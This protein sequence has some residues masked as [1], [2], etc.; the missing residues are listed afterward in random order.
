MWLPGHHGYIV[1]L[2]SNGAAFTKDE[3]VQSPSRRGDGLQRA[4]DTALWEITPLKR[5]RRQSGSVATQK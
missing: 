4:R 1:S 5:A 3:D 2:A